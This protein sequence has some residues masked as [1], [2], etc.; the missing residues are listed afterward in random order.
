MPLGYVPSSGPAPLSRRLFGSRRFSRT[1]EFRIMRHWLGARGGVALDLGAGGGEFAAQLAS[2]GYRVVALDLDRQAIE[3]GKSERYRNVSW[4][5]GDATRP[6]ILSAAVDVVLCN[7]AIEHF[8]DDEATVRELR[9]VLKPGGRIVLTTDSLPRRPSHWLRWVPA[10]WRREDLRVGAGL[11]QALAESHRRRH[12]VVRFYDAQR[13]TALL[14]GA[15]FRVDDWRYY[16]NG[17]VSQGIF[18][19][20]LMLAALDFYN[21]LSRRLY[22]LFFPFTFPIVRRRP[23]YGLA[24]LAHRGD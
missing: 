12:H 17:P 24:V 18:E 7:S 21:G 16:L 22:P 23:G 14:E 4:L 15:G 10:S 8:P 19:A 1:I 20:H 13:L 11:Q 9:R 2:L 5:Q 3:M 6:P